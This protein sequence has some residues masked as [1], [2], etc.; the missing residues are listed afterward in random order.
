MTLNEALALINS[1]NAATPVTPHWLVCGFEPLHLATLLRGHLLERLPGQVELRSGVYGDIFGNLE[2]AVASDA[3]AAAVVIEWPDLNPLLGLRASGGWAEDAKDSIV[4]T[5]QKRLAL[6]EDRLGSL[7]TRMPV[8]VAPPNLPCPPIGG[9]PPDQQSRFELELN[10]SVDSFL[11]RVSHLPGVRIARR[12]DASRT[13][14]ALDSRMELIAGFPYTLPFADSLASSIA[15]VLWPSSPR[16]GLITD[17]DDTLW[18]GIVGEVGPDAV[19]WSQEAHTQTHGLYQQM[20]GYLASSG[21]LVGISSKNDPHT[22]RTAL[23]REDLFVAPD[24]FFPVEVGWGPKSASVA[25]ILE[26]WNISADSVVFIDDSPMEIEEVRSNHPGI[27]GLHFDGKDPRKV[28]TLL[29]TL[30]TLFGRP[31]FSDEDKLRQASIRSSTEIGELVA[32][33]PAGSPQ[34]LRELQ[35]SV[36]LA[37][38]VPLHDNRAFE[39][40]NKTNQFNLNGRRISEGAW[41]RDLEDSAGVILVLSYADRFGPLGRIAVLKG[42]RHGDTVHVTHWVMSCRAFSRRLE[43]HALDGLFRQTG[44]TAV[45]FDYEATERNGPLREFFHAIGIAVDAP[46]TVG[47][48]REE[49]AAGEFVL[50]HTIIDLD[51]EGMV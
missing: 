7:G 38:Q 31:A 10:C 27:T 29:Q 26:T 37:W 8:A 12:P 16:K 24:T 43:Y 13:D 39:L 18:R 49:F 6:L 15:A 17:L 22:V 19:T 33:V 25:R 21:V 40:V 42:S 11:L 1:R 30:R 47:I 50:P 28:W 48:S 5:V 3:I 2:S 34:F 35:G 20:L 51:N 36:T 46:G 41:R 4:A 23:A 44:A 14:A 32:N 9:T 45:T